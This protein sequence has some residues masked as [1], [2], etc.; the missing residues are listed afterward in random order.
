M[1]GLAGRIACPLL[2]A[3]FWAANLLTAQ[4]APVATTP[5]ADHVSLHSISIS[6]SS[7]IVR[8]RNLSPV[9]I[10]AVP[11]GTGIIPTLASCSE[12]PAELARQVSTRNGY[13]RSR[14]RQTG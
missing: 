7:F 10:C 12:L 1:F 9:D 2:P 11:T 13:C 8:G 3:L 14:L 6:R 4:T 5:E